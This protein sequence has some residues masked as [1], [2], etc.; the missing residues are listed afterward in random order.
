MQ[1]LP[2]PKPMNYFRKANVTI[3][4]TVFVHQMEIDEYLVEH[5]EVSEDRAFEI[6]AD[7]KIDEQTSGPSLKLRDYS[8]VPGTLQ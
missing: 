6:L 3:Q 4:A 8:I 5:P 1:T 2:S 7:A